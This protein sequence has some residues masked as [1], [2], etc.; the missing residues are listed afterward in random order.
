MYFTN[1]LVRY[2]LEGMRQHAPELFRGP[3]RNRTSRATHVT[4]GSPLRCLHLSQS[5]FR[6]G[7]YVDCTSLR[8]GKS[9]TI[10]P[11]NG[12]GNIDLTRRGRLICRT[13]PPSCVA[14]AL[15]KIAR[16]KEE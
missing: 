1:T 3:N 2:N 6:A 11:R 12:I 7:N 13:E 16:A 5:G 10:P 9:G 8:A 4:A 15:T 14:Q